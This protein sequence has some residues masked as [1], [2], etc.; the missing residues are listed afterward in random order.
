MPARVAAAFLKTAL[1]GCTLVG[2][3][4]EGVRQLKRVWAGD[5]L[6]T[7][8]F[9]LTVRG[10]PPAEGA[11]ILV[12]NHVSYL[13]IPL[14]MASEGAAVFIS[15]D[16]LLKWPFIGIGAKAIGTIFVSRKSGADRSAVREQIIRGLT[17]E[18][19]GKIVVFPA[20][21]TTLDESVRWK[22]GIFE[23]AKAAKVPVQ[24][25]HIQYNP[26]REAAYIDDDNLLVQ[27]TGLSKV[28]NKTATLTWLERF[29]EI[30]EPESFA[31]SLRLK[32][33]GGILSGISTE[34][35]NS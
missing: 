24:L 4:E 30:G 33:S 8:G 28:K 21:T 9:E 14:V 15:K 6:K 22:R 31:E 5:L 3:S 35:R 20:G 13:D 27:M 17:K 2:K 16:D 25:F 23:I 10:T 32:V 1:Y 7:L 34:S 18:K 26:M 12:G 11:C 19:N 29:D